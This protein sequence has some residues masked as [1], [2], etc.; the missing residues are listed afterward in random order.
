MSARAL[1][2]SLL[3][4]GLPAAASAQPDTARIGLYVVDI[5]QIN[6]RENTFHIELDVISSWVDPERATGERREFGDAEATKFL[7][8]GWFPRAFITNAKAGLNIHLQHT[9][10][11]PDGRVVNRARLEAVI[12]APLD[13]REFPFDSQALRI[14]VESYSHDAEALTLVLDEDFSGFDRHFQMPEWEVLGTEAS[15]SPVLREQDQRTYSRLDFS[16]NVQRR[17]GYYLWKVVLPLVLITAISW[18]VFWMSSDGL[19]RRAGITATGM[20]TVIAYQFIIAG[21]LPRFPY[22]TILDKVT[23]L[24]LVLIALT[25]LEN[26]ATARLAEEQRAR[27]DQASRIAFPLALAA[28]LAATM[29]PSLIT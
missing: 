22:L 16:V 23:L 26:L 17:V 11:H 19:G 20:L 13:F 10:L 4:L 14:Q 25:M 27:F 28:G 8:Q 5:A 7:D 15:A 1:F 9:T 2:L 18:V 21:M 24:A 3:V 29:I 6:E 12:R